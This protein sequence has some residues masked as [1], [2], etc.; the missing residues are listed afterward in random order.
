[1]ENIFIYL[2]L[3]LNALLEDVDICMKTGKPEITK[4]ILNYIFKNKEFHC[5]LQRVK[6]MQLNGEYL[7]ETNAETFETVLCK[8]FMGS[9]ELLDKYNTSQDSIL[10]KYPDLFT[11]DE[12][13]V[14]DEESKKS[15]F[16][17][18]AKYADREYTQVRS[19]SHIVLTTNF[20]LILRKFQLNN[21][22]NSDQFNM[23]RQIMELNR[24][25]AQ[26]INR[27]NK[28]R[29][30]QVSANFMKRTSHIDEQEIKFIEEKL[31]ANLC[32]A[33]ENYMKFSALDSAISSPVIYRIICLWFA[34]KQNEALRT[35]IQEHINNVPSYKFIC[36]L[37]QMTARLNSENTEFIKILK[38]IMVRCVVDHPQQTLYQLYPI[39][40]GYVDGT[41]NK[42]DYRSQIAQDIIAKAKVHINPSI[43]KQLEMAIPGESVLI[44]IN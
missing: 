25:T 17:I 35:K 21:Y 26:Q 29:D 30:K 22:A 11:T 14:C 33:V 19:S 28:D 27:N 41:Q 3:Q 37:N 42:T 32:I 44:F 23:K 2:N 20:Q 40:Y 12:L 7:M 13:K 36:A 43:V 34:N 16:E 39:V 1:M 9:L 8:Y 38:E 6:A 10:Q 31:T 4:S 15:A 18:I 24:Q 5:C